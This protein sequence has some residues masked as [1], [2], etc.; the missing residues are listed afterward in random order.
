MALALCSLKE[1]PSLIGSPETGLGAAEALQILMAECVKPAS[2]ALRAGLHRR[3]LGGG[4]T[5]RLRESAKNW[6]PAYMLQD[7]KATAS[8]NENENGHLHS[9]PETCVVSLLPPRT[10]KVELTDGF[11]GAM[12]RFASL[13]SIVSSVNCCNLF[14]GY[15]QNLK[16]VHFSVVCSSEKVEML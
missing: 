16:D 2:R 4:R 9:Q 3:Q 5:L 11:P 8:P 7:M 15:C 10:S 14:G 13:L 1:A 6:T 12:E